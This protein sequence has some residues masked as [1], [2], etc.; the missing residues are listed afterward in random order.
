MT[1]HIVHFLRFAL[2]HY[3]YWTVALL[4]LLENLGLPLP[5]E[6]VLMLAS[7]LAY[8]EH[9]LQ[10][11]WI[12]AAGIAAATLGSY[13]GYAVG[14]Y[15]GRRLIE[16]LER[17]FRISPK[18]FERGE[19]LFQEYGAVTILF[20]RFVFGMRV[21]AGPIAGV[22]RMPWKK[23]A[24]YNVM[25]AALWV[26]VMSCVGYFFGS[27]WSTMVS[28]MKKFDQAL[29]AAFILVGLFLWWRR[30]KSRMGEAHP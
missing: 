25:G 19:K 20:A 13:C 16:R 2:V 18:A 14:N 30:R 27:R 8:T 3:G 15:G 28:F 21:L 11:G 12:I 29:V 1:H 17:T 9:D 10:V 7:F 5:G 6:T 26:S 23:F 24:V 4:L 22:L